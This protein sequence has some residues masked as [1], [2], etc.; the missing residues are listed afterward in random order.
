MLIA[1]KLYQTF[2]CGVT[3]RD[4]ITKA[5]KKK[6]EKANSNDKVIV[7]RGNKSQHI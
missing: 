3:L 1:Y 6:A 7:R 5:K 2:K 4:G